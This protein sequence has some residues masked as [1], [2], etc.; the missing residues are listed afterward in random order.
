MGS[1]PMLSNACDDIQLGLRLS[2]LPN[3]GRTFTLRFQDQ[4]PGFH[5]GHGRF[6]WICQQP[7]FCPVGIDHGQKFH[8]LYLCEYQC[9]RILLFAHVFAKHGNDCLKNTRVHFFQKVGKRERRNEDE[10]ITVLERRKIKI[11]KVYFAL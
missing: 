2:R 4:R 10:R 9:P 1:N 5:Y 3:D 8:F 7:I 6:I 11:F